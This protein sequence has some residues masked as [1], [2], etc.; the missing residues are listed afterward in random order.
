MIYLLPWYLTISILGWLS[1]PLAYRLL[2]ALS[3]RGYAVSRA[4]GLMIW[5]YFFWLLASLG[6][7]RNNAGGLLFALALLGGLS[8]WAL[9]AN[10]QEMVA[11]LSEKRRMLIVTELLFLLAF[12]GW[13]VVRGFNPEAV[14][15]E[16]PME[17]AFINAILNSPTFPPHDP[18]LAGYA[19]SYYYFGYVMVAMVAKLTATSGAIAFNLGLALVFG[20]AASGAYS[21]V[22]NLLAAYINAPQRVGR[23]EKDARTSHRP[24]VLAPLLGP[25][26]ILLVS[27]L[28]GFLHS[29]HTRGLLWR[30]EMPESPNILVSNFWRWLDIKD[31]N[32]PPTQPFSWV[33]SRFWWWW[34]ASRVIQDYDLAGNVKEIINEFPFFSFLLGDLHPHVLAIPFAFL[35]MTLSLNLFLGGARGQLNWFRRRLNL[36]TLAWTATLAVPLGITLLV[37]GAR[38]MSIVLVLISILALGVGAWL[39]YILREALLEHGLDLLA[40]DDLGE[41]VIG[42]SL[43]ISPVM[44]VASA[45]VLGGTFFLNAWDF[46]F[47]VAL[48]ASAYLLDRILDTGERFWPA[49]KDFIWLGLW[50]GV[51]GGLF[52]LPFY[53]SF[54]SQAGGLLPNLAYPTRGAHLWV[55]F[56]PLLYPLFIFL[57]RLV[58]RYRMPGHNTA[59]MM[60]KALGIT[61]GSFLLLWLAAILFSYAILALPQIGDFYLGVLGGS[62]PSQLFQAG[63]IRRLTNTG[64]W[65]TLAAL[66]T[67]LLTIFLPLV[68]A[69]KDQENQTGSDLAIKKNQVEAQPIITDRIP[70]D[71]QSDTEEHLNKKSTSA[72]NDRYRLPPAHLFALLMTALGGLLVLGPEFFYLRDQFGWRINTIFKFYYLAWL[73]WGIAAAYA[74]LVLLNSKR[75]LVRLLFGIG[76]AIMLGASLVY[77]LYALPNKTNNFSS[78]E[79][80]LDSSIHLQHSAPDELAAIQ[81][82]QQAPSGIIAEGVPEAGG[83]YTNFARQATHSGKPNLLGWVGHESQ[84]RGGGKEMGSRKADLA[85]LYCTRDWRTARD[86]V[87]KYNIRYIVAGPLEYAAYPAETTACPAGVVEAK[88]NQFA[89]VAF[90]QGSVTIYEYVEGAR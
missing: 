17:L 55:M 36:R 61:L 31:L 34:R 3:D 73:L 10:W 33:P 12:T 32:L 56:A 62:D 9:V 60:V 67:F 69:Q 7:L 39:V 41:M 78:F 27:N 87:I 46:P 57:I 40:R 22:Y 72:A 44:F 71:V 90:Q 11:W 26:F 1:F 30:S 29:L 59:R 63:L 24:P 21:L 74:S 19:I 88:F 13:A 54:S 77:P 43:A 65:L 15:T 52:Y 80:S 83:S 81:W 47:Y 82:F 4:L 76:L 38:T 25:I 42:R 51:S 5:S 6:I 58:L 23:T 45:I 35:A 70:S 79:A 50:I 86:I 2:P 49:F 16:K 68:T 48:F 85:T 18:W 64:G 89:R 53:I 84:W 8:I 20:L 28:E 66:F 75:A 37:L 14:G